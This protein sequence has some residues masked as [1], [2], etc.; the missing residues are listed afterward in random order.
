MTGSAPQA[1]I[2]TYKAADSLYG[3][4]WSVCPACMSLFSAFSCARL[5][6]GS[7]IA[8]PS[9]VLVSRM[10]EFCS[11]LKFSLLFRKHGLGFLCFCY[12]AWIPS[13]HCQ[14]FCQQRVMLVVVKERQALARKFVPEREV[15][16]QHP[17]VYRSG[18]T[19]RSALL[20]EA[21]FRTTRT[22]LTSLI[23]RAH[24]SINVPGHRGVCVYRPVWHV[25]ASTA[26]WVQNAVQNAITSG[27][28]TWHDPSPN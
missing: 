27:R 6:S 17:A 10:M 28:C 13:L 3:L 15:L 1:Q 4:S 14:T 25:V 11:V 19:S 9:H 18:R 8:H 16:M 26:T 2:Y 7:S 20:S 21:S 22:M 23:V 24:H 12:R 5:T